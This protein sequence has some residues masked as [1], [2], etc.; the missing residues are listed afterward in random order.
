MKIQVFVSALAV[1]WAFASTAQAQVPMVK[2]DNELR[3]S[4]KEGEVIVK[5]RDGAV[6]SF[7]AMDTLYKRVNVVDVKRFSGEFRNFEHLI[8]DTTHLSVEQAVADLQRDPT[9]EYAQ[10]NYMLYASR[11]QLAKPKTLGEPCVIPGIPFPPGCEDSGSTPGNPPPGNTGTPPPAPSWR[12]GWP[13]TR[14]WR[15]SGPC[16]TSLPGC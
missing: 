15:T 7:A 16:S 4:Y 11:A 6:R 2:I 1:V 10:P 8:F 13:S 12:C 3:P 5:F 9:V 14:S